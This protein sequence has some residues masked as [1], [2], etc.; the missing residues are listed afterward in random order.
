VARCEAVRVVHVLRQKT[1]AQD[2]LEYS[3]PKIP[4]VLDSTDLTNLLFGTD[5]SVDR[6]GKALTLD[7]R[8]IMTRAS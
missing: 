2:G 1:I 6:L 8:F 7:C 5:I 4:S 3:L